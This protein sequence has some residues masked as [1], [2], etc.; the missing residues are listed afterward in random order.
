MPTQERLEKSI[1]QVL[2]D[3]GIIDL[4]FTGSVTIHFSQGGLSEIDRIEKNLRKKLICD[5]E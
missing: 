1:T 5:K 2:I 3:S 4:K